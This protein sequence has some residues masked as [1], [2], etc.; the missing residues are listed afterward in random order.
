MNETGPLAIDAHLVPLP[1]ASAG[2]T[3]NIQLRMAKG[4]WRLDYVALASLDDCNEVIELRPAQVMSYDQVNDEA[5]ARLLDS[6]RTLIT[7]PGDEFVIDYE[8][9]SDGRSYELFVKSRGYYLE[10]MRDEWMR[11]E[12]FARAAEMFMAPDKALRR[13]AP[14]FKEVEDEMEEVF[15]NS[16]YAH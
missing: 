14:E 13:M 10:W 3:L 8:L 5:R 7:F 1:N 15:W 4:H 12:N 9:P 2:D 16:K 6:S 11:E